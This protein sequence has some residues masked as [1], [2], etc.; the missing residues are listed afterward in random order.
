MYGF[1]GSTRSDILKC[2]CALIIIPTNPNSRNIIS[3]KFKRLFQLY[4]VL[5]SS[6]QLH[7]IH[8]NLVLKVKKN[9]VKKRK[10]LNVFLHTPQPFQDRILPPQTQKFTFSQPNFSPVSWQHW[11]K[12]ANTWLVYS[13]SSVQSK[14][15]KP[16][17][18][19]IQEVSNCIPCWAVGQ[20][21]RV[22]LL[23]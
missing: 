7:G 16:N 5:F 23:A 22:R 12:S 18:P 15:V 13:R 1:S 20:L 19:N 6:F 17:W 8:W 2:V 4:G 14:T 21:A 3:V 9:T 10:I 11:T